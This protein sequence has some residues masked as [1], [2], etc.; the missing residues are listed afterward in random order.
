M[1]SSVAAAD[2]VTARRRVA[3]LLLWLLPAIW[4]SNYLI[5]RSAG[6]H[7]PPHVLAFG[8]WGI[9]F[10]LLLAFNARSIAS[11]PQRLLAEW[12]QSLV[13]GAL[14]MWICGAW[15]YLAGHT[16]STTNLSLIYA[17]APV[18]IALAGQRLLGE[19]LG[20]AQAVAML[21]S[22][23]GV[24]FVVLHGDPGSLLSVRFVV[25]DLW[26]LAATI[27]W[28]GYSVLQQ[29]FRTR[30]S[31]TE[32]LCS[33]AAGG[34]VVMLPFVAWELAAMTAPLDAKAW[35]LIVLAALLPG[36]LSYLTY[37]F[38]QRELGV[39]RAGL[40]IYLAPIYAAGLA[41]WLLGEVPQWYHAVGAMLILPSIHIATRRA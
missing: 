33:M 37:D 3:L 22:L 13:L 26:I 4:S 5:A 32:R 20:R 1:R 28:I 11:H 7:V 14:G 23:A 12:R 36:L 17:A 10:A 27:S 41:W 6:P 24:I 38:L 35:Q 2:R 16:T 31:P 15:V 34:L 39:A 30:L 18:G 9:V 19:R 40:V 29:Y 21:L 25:G 8:R